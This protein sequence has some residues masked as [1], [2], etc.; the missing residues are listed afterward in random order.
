MELVESII[1]I[2]ELVGGPIVRYLKYQMNF[3]DYLKNFKESK[4]KLQRKQRDIDSTLSSQ[5]VHGKKAKEEVNHWL[6]EVEEITGPVAK[7]I[8]DKIEKGGWLLRASGSLAKL[9]EEKI[10]EMERLCED[11]SKLPESLVVDDPSTSTTE[12]QTSQIQGSYDVKAEILAWLKGEEVTKLGVWGMGGVGKTTIMMHVHNEL[13]KEGKFN[14]IILVTVSQNFEIY[15]LQ[16][17]IA[18]SLKENLDQRQN[19]INRAAMLSKMLEKHKPFLLILDDVWSSFNLEV[20]GIPEPNVT[21][22]CKLVLTT[23]SQEVARSMDCRRIKVETL[24]EDEALKLFLNKVGDAA[25]SCPGGGIKRD[26]ESTLKDIVDECDGLPLALITVASSLK[27]IS[28]SRLWSDALNQLR[29]CKRNVAGTDADAFQILKFSYDRLENP[30]IKYCFLYC[31][32]YPEDY[33][34]LEEEIIENWIDEGFIDEMESQQSMKDA[35]YGFLKKLEDNSLLE[36]IKDGFKGDC[37]RMHD[38]IRDMALHIT[39]TSPR[40]L[41]EAGKALKELPERANCVEGVEKVSLMHNY[42]KEIPSS[43]AFSTCI[44]L[45]TL[46]LAHNRLSTIPQSVFEHMPE[47]KVLDLSF[48]QWLCNLPNSVSKLVKLTTL[49]LEETSLE[50]VQSL[51]GLGS[52]KKLNLRRTKIKEVPEGLGMLKNLKCLFLCR[53][54]YDSLERDGIA[55]KGDVVGRLKKLEVF[56][57]WFPTA[58]EMRIFL[59]CEPN[60]LS[61]YYIIVGSI[62]NMPVRLLK[63]SLR[64]KKMMVLKGIS[65]VGENMLFPSVQELWID[66]CHDMRSLNDISVIKDATELGRCTIQ[67][68]DGMEFVL[69][70][71]INNPVVQTLQ[72]LQ[73]YKLHKLD[74]LFEANV[75]ATSS[76]PPRAFSSLREVEIEECK[77]IKKL[78]PSWKLVECLQS[79]KDIWVKDCE[80]MEELIGSDPKEEGGDTIKKLILPKLKYLSLKNL[81]ALKS[82]CSRR[83][84]MVCESIEIYGCKG[85]RRMPLSLPLV[86]NAQLSPP[87]I[88]NI[89]IDRGELEWW[90]A[91]QWD[92]PNAKDLLRPMVQFFRE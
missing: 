55:M 87:S 20:V 42:I 14:K 53:S 7:D 89:L 78:F 23:R 6:E 66:T 19:A 21:N 25:L 57:G 58:N 39:R 5:L 79:L 84:V 44:R 77:K 90:E 36:V 10:Q 16:D 86:D 30:K 35:G 51:S 50:K 18:S 22:G 38:L 76:P 88:K 92:H 32:L 46:L 75:M 8:E 67:N 41:V 65:I 43:L 69:S 2:V 13:L 11:G 29:D 28:E 81:P 49:L 71:W 82:I 47:L 12:L 1:K 60:R 68:C 59:K 56:H 85:L 27:G 31:A 37:V 33:K 62:L 24:S 15:N 48:N 80:E 70:S 3:N 83:A 61:D 73:L 40:F 63:W 26:L 74:G 17:Q 9:L 45:T 72:F 91:L 34:I 4:E 54:L 64:Y 52:L